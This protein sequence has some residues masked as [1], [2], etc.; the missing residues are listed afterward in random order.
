MSDPK[1]THHAIDYIEL[2]VTDM[3]QA[4]RFYSTAFGWKLTEYGPAYTGIQR[5]SGEGE[6]GG[7]ALAE[8]VTRGGALVILFSDTLEE[9]LEQV[10]AAGGQIVKEIFNFPGGR[11]FQFLDPSGNELAAWGHSN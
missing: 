5:M 7:L 8:S 11:R 9:T 1:N 3:E 2:S 10:K 6:S 4:K